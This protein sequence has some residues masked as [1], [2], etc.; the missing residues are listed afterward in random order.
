MDG[1]CVKC[2]KMVEMKDPKERKTKNNRRM[3]QG[4]CPNCGTKVSKFLPNK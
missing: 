3:A 1:Y 4:L 2:R